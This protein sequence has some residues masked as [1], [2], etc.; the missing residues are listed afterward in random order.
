MAHSIDSVSANYA[1]SPP[2]C[3]P[4]PLVY[5]ESGK[6]HL[7]QCFPKH[8]IV[9]LNESNFIQWQQHIKLIIEGYELTEFVDRS[10]QPPPHFV[11]NQEGKLVLNLEASLL[12][13]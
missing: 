12:L 7:V 5:S 3:D 9:K 4:A 13:Q 10:I 2:A 8:D 1:N 6:T 11:S